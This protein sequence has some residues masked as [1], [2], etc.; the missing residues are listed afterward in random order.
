MSPEQ[1]ARTG[2][3]GRSDVFAAGI[4]LWEALTGKELFTCESHAETLAKVLREPVPPPSSFADVPEAL[5][6]ACM[7]ALE[8]TADR[9][10]P[11]AAAF[12]AVLADALPLASHER[13]AEIVVGVGAE[14]LE[15]QRAAREAMAYA[16]R[17][18]DKDP[19]G[20]AETVPAFV[21]AEDD[22]LPIRSGRPLRAVAI[23]AAA[24][25]LVVLGT[26]LGRVSS[27]DGAARA[28]GG[29]T[30]STASVVLASAAAPSA[31]SP[32]SATAT[33]EDPPIEL[34]STPAVPAPSPASAPP[35]RSPKRSPGRGRPP[36]AAAASTAHT[37]ASPPAA[38]AATTASA[39]KSDAPFIPGE[40]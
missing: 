2:V 36:A 15:R 8:R 40:L 31:S 37:A 13:V 18:S 23:G 27:T 14:P 24:A 26:V 4:V 6:D 17:S 25:V 39:K 21:A 7:K 38:A 16:P 12:A 11:S 22:P 29:S 10:F 1:I 19:R 20:I 34:G 28:S 9:R 33:A 30:A 32:A 3:D 5:E 35:S